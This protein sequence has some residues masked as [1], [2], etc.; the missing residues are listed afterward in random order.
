MS[1]GLVFWSAERPP[2]QITKLTRTTNPIYYAVE[3]T[4]VRDCSRER[5]IGQPL[6]AA[7]ASVPPDYGVEH[8]TLMLYP[9]EDDKAEGS[10]RKADSG[11]FAKREKRRNQV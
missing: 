11:L 1:A 7:L 10:F 8:R 6:R 3:Y 9:R 4:E 5:G 2:L